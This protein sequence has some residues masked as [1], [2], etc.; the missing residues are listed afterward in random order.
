DNKEQQDTQDEDIIQSTIGNFGRWQFKISGLMALLKFP[1]AIRHENDSNIIMP[2]MNGYAYNTTTFHS[3]IIT[4]WNLV[5]DNKRLV[6]ISQVTL[7]LGVLIDRQGRKR[8]LLICI[9]LQS[10]FGIAAAGIPWYWGFVAARFLLAVANGGTIVTSFVMCMEVVGGTW[11]S[12]VPILYQIP[13][14]FGNSIMAGLAYFYRDWRDLQL[15]LSLMSAF[16]ILYIWFIPESPRWL[17]ATG[18]KDEAI[19]ILQNAA[20]CNKLDSDKVQVIANGIS[21]TTNAENKASVSGLLIAGVTFYAFSQYV[22]KVGSNLYFTA[23]ISGFV[24]LPGT[25]LCVF[26]IRRYGR[27]MTIASAHILTASCF[28][29]ILAVPAGTYNHDWPR[30]AIAGVGVVGLSISMPALYLFTGEL[31]PTTIRN[32]GVG[33]SVMFSRMG[34][35]I[36]PLVITMQ[37][38][39]PSLPLIVLGISAVI[40]TLLIL[41]LPETKGIPLPE[42]IND[43]EFK[44]VN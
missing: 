28:F 12:I 31:F 1:I 41:P 37:D 15:A 39:S 17:L 5:C 4:E 10:L 6:D 22:G 26:I 25:L 44:K 36:A 8:T 2:C 30:V 32:A 29:G 16:Y 11:R 23:A 9:V 34:S 7:M 43:L 42:T 35:M 38:I 20:R 21:S 3:T 40:E 33:T 13:Y 19:Q 24:A 18:R 27:R 14:G